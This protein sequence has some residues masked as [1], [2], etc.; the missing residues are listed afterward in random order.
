MTRIPASRRPARRRSVN[1]LSLLRS[2]VAL[3]FRGVANGVD[4]RTAQ[5]RTFGFYR[6]TRM[7]WSAA[8]G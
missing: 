1:T 2:R 8:L 5:Q 4:P 6:R 7:G 3:A